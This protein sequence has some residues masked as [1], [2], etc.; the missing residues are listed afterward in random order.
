MTLDG[1]VWARASSEL[2]ALRISVASTIF[3][4]SSPDQELRTELGSSNRGAWP[5]HAAYFFFEPGEDRCSS[6]MGPELF[7]SDTPRPAIPTFCRYLRSS[8]RPR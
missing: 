7:E 8:R 3:W 2:S 4:I 1:L 6:G 5:K